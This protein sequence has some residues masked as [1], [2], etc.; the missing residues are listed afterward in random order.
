MIAK[1]REAMTTCGSVRDYAVSE[2]VK[3]LVAKGWD[4]PTRTRAAETT[5]AKVD[6][7]W[8]AMGRQYQ[9]MLIRR[10]AELGAK[11]APPKR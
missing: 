6:E 5:F 4:E 11:A 8:F 7:S 3:A 9:E 10:A 2:A 1:F